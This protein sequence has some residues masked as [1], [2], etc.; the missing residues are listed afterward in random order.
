[1]GL[2]SYQGVR[3]RK[4]DMG[5]ISLLDFKVVNTVMGWIDTIY[6]VRD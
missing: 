2:T 6:V 5:S 1:M 3:C 4:Y